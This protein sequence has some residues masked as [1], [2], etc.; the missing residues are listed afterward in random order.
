MVKTN[1]IKTFWEKNMMNYDWKRKHENETQEQMLKRTKKTLF[2]HSP[3]IKEIIPKIKGKKVLDI[4]CGTGIISDYMQKK[5][6][7]THAIDLTKKA[8]T[9]TRKR[10]QKIKTK[11]ANAEKL[12]YKNNTFDFIITWGVIHHAKNT[13]K[14][15]KE[16]ARTLK[17]GGKTSGMIYNKN[18][19]VY[20]IHIILLRGII[21]GKLLKYK[22]EQLANKYTDGKETGGNPKATHYTPKQWKETMEKNGL[23]TKIKIRSMKTDLPI[24]NLIL[25]KTTEKILK[26]YGWFIIWKAT[27]KHKRSTC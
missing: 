18:S 2:K 12:P 10:N 11:Q 9:T 14:C 7:K 23:K 21:M 16:I 8:I 24:I 13:E 15:V 20:Y 6:A 17:E 19:I 5:G 27:K 1:E 25:P 22:P 3:I 26:K 4:G